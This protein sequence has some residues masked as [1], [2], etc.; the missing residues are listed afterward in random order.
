MNLIVKIMICRFWEINFT[1]RLL[2]ETETCEWR[3]DIV[4]VSPTGTGRS[5]YHLFCFDVRHWE[6]LG[7]LPKAIE[8]ILLCKKWIF[9]KLKIFYLSPIYF[10]VHKKISKIFGT[11]YYIILFKIILNSI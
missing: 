9:N 6:I 7:P 4:Y 11:S 5:E 8:K 3:A 2:T 1:M 10:L